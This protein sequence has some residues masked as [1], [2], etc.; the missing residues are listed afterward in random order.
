MHPRLILAFG[1]GTGVLFSGLVAGSQRVACRTRQTQVRGFVPVSP[2][3]K[4][5]APIA[6]SAFFARGP[7]VSRATPSPN[8]ERPLPAGTP[9]PEEG[10][11]EEEDNNQEGSR[12]A[13]DAKFQAA[14][15]E[16]RDDAWAAAMEKSLELALEKV[17][18]FAPVAVGESDCRTHH[19]IFNIEWNDRDAALTAAS[20]VL[21]MLPDECAATITHSDDEQ[22]EYDTYKSRVLL[23]CPRSELQ[24]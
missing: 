7:H 2:A 8:A 20:D 21:N 13:L 14:R 17:I 4:P 9:L 19:C 16:A 22:D 1:I 5:L 3:H 24:R 6:A 11:G 15:G 12:R 10:E 18:A 23:R